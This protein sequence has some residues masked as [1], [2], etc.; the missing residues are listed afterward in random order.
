MA[1][2]LASCATADGRVQVIIRG[3]VLDST[4]S[5]IEG[6]Q[7]FVVGE[8]LRC[9]PN[10]SRPSELGCFTNADGRFQLAGTIVRG[11][12]DLR[13]QRTGQSP[14]NVSV[15]VRRGGAIELGVISVGGPRM[16]SN[17]PR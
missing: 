13:V 12:R 15:D 6:V 8:D 4:R 17:G 14:T 1:L 9:L 10:V 11:R 2:A 16:H 7:V 5:P 3:T